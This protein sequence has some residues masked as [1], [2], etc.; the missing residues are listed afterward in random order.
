MGRD[1]LVTSY[2]LGDRVSIR[3]RKH[4]KTQTPIRWV[5]G[6]FPRGKATVT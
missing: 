6:I 5:P 2:G 4:L 3:G 1:M